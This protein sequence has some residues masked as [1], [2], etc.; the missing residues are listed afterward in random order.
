MFKIS[1]SSLCSWK[2]KQNKKEKIKLCKFKLIKL[3]IIQK[4]FARLQKPVESLQE[5]HSKKWREAEKEGS[6]G[7]SL[8][9][10]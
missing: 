1:I 3:E 5:T 10:Y 4:V 8:R 2:F 9:N 7:R 6:D